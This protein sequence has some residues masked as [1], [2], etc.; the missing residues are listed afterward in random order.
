VTRNTGEQ[1]VR[2][3]EGR[4]MAVY[5]ALLRGIN[6]A[7][8]ILKMDRLRAIWSEM[9]FSNVQTY[10]Q[11]GNIVFEAGGI[12]LD[13][14]ER[15][16]QK[17]VGETRL[18]VAVIVRSAGELGKVIVGNPFLKAGGVDESKLH[19]T[20]LENSSTKEAVQRLGEIISG[21]DGYRVVNREVYLHCP[22]GYGRTKL[23]NNRL[24]KVLAMRA[25]TRNWNTV[26]AL[27]E[28][29]RQ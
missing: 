17:L 20:F 13:W 19:V 8:N 28:L 16:E 7:G 24:E 18:P 27:H 1:K 4:I 25:T 14:R 29:A 6:V 22:D 26:K 23:S 12:P 10:L 3:Y 11:S 9:G 5:V 21:Q 2:P 15:I